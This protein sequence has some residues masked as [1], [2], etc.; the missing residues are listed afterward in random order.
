MASA[1]P[2]LAHNPLQGRTGAMPT[3]PLRMSGGAIAAP[4]CL[5]LVLLACV[6][7]LYPTVP[8]LTDL[9]AHMARYLV[10]TDAG[11]SSDIARWYS[12]HWKLIPNL[13]ADLLAQVLVPRLGL[14][15]AVKAIAVLIIA[16]QVAGYLTLSRVLHGKVASPALFAIPLAYGSP[17][18]YGFL[19]FTLAVAL[20]T[21]ALALW[22]SPWMAARPRWRWLLFCMIA[23]VLWLCHLAGWA[24]LCVMIG[25]CELVTRWESSR[26][27]WPALI[28]SFLSCT[29]L[30]VP[31]VASMLLLEAPERLPTA[32][33]FQLPYK[34]YFLLNVLAD[35]WSLLDGLS[36]IALIVLL[37]R[38]RR[39]QALR[40]DHRLGFAAVVLLLVFFVTPAWV[41]GSFYADMRLLPTVFAL[42]ILALRPAEHAD[43]RQLRL[44]AI[45]GIAFFM[46]RIGSNTASMALWDRQIHEQIQ[47]LDAVPAGSQLV[48]FSSRPCKDVVLLGR[49]RNTHLTSYA[50]THRHAFAND[51]FEMSGGQLLSVSN[52]ALAPFETDPSSLEVGEKC[53][54]T[55]PLL[56]SVARLP[57]AAR[58]L[59]IVWSVPEY[60]IPKWQILTQSGSSVLYIR[61]PGVASSH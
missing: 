60:S 29:C 2:A 48:T 16:L 55:I 15:P 51:Q 36:A 28:A 61:E 41:F 32:G 4:W 5:A 6:P 59:W 12:F 35:R 9:P 33:F 3:K 26:R 39:S 50:L 44:I 19:N 18:Q 47:V 52:P 58:Y 20:A 1:D 17:F 13:G 30:L 56:D 21:L 22:M 53:Q 31:Q 49:D 14:E 7:L 38:V 46:V 54:G 34:F 43:P 40:F 23:A 24:V 42:A 57:P 8:P 11:R 37:I 45:M 25:C 10:Q 27:F